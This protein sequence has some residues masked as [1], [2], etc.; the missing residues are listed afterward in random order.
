MST[1]KQINP[2]YVGMVSGMASYIDSAAIVSNGTALVIYQKALGTTSVEIGILSGLLTLCIAL[3]A[4]L[5]GRLGDCYG[6]R[7][8]FITTMAM[9]IIGT[10]L[11]AFGMNFSM[12]LVGTVF[13]GL[14]TGADL[15]VSLAT[16]AEAAVD[17][18]RGKIIGLSNI[19]WL[20]GIVVTMGISATVGG[21][22]HSGAQI[23]YLHVCVVAMILLVLR[24]SIPESPL[25]LSA[26]KEQ[27][28]GVLT[29]RAQKTAFKDL[30]NGKYLW[31]F[32]ALCLF[33]TF[34][35][36]AANT[37]GQFG[38]YIAVNVVG[39]SVETN[40][41][42][43]LLTMPIGM[44]AGIFFMRFVDTSKR[45][46]TFILGAFCFAGGFF[47]PVIFNFSPISW[48]CFLFF[49]AIGS[50]LAFEGIMKVW[51]Q[52]SF[53]TM[54]RSTAQ[55]IIVAIS[56]LSCGLLA[57]VTPLLLDAGPTAL[58]SILS[59]VVT[60]G[61]LIGWFCFH[62]KPRNEFKSEAETCLEESQLFNAEFPAAKI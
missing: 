13:V 44:V 16:I 20:L 26:R 15:P 9:I 29:V 43:N 32:V 34:T 60:L 50:G 8:V 52:E 11:L 23:M 59:I 48:F 61:L 55:G 36:L 25:W 49:T 4:F 2:W 33:Y 19:L 41:W 62:G 53:Q 7:R 30:I 51:S 57:F 12:L 3:G 46:L 42:W 40:A 14:G 6:R 45:M 56:R 10:L 47:M 39:I 54:L 21:W 1:I 28:K 35:N 37:G 22:G 58:Y 31:P 27:K 18:N 24:C 5:G 17:K 38:T